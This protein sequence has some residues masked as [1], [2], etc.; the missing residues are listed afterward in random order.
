[1]DLYRH[2]RS[3]DVRPPPILFHG[4]AGQPF[5]DFSDS[6]LGRSSASPA[7]RLGHYF[8]TSPDIAAS[9]A[10]HYSVLDRAYDT[11]SG[12]RVLLD[13]DWIGRRDVERDEGAWL[14]GA[15]VRLATAALHHIARVPAATFSEAVDEGF[16]DRDWALLRSHLLADGYD[17]VV[18][19]ADFEA[20]EAG[21]LCF[22]YAAD[23]WVALRGSSLRLPNA[24]ALGAAAAVAQG[25][26]QSVPSYRR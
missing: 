26:I 19:E 15:T 7:A 18:I 11:L 6:A 5:T 9:F 4:T 22:E 24:A 12:S 13:P 20:F 10:L 14:P 21:D 8:S 3:S 16:P 23:T 2:I 17:G 25:S 1:M